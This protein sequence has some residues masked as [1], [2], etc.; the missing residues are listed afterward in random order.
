MRAPRRRLRTRARRRSSTSAR[1]AP[2]PSSRAPA[3][4]LRDAAGRGLMLAS[5]NRRGRQTMSSFASE[6]QLGGV[7]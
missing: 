2:S 4:A 6:A 7:P 5:L 3:D 1:S